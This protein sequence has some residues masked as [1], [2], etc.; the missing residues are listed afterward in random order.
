MRPGTEIRFKLTLDYSVLPE[1]Y[2]A[3]TLM[4]MI[5]EFD[6]YYQRTYLSRFTPPYDAHPVSYKNSLIL[7]GGAGFFAKTLAYPYLGVQQ[8]MP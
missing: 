5:G 6:A 8:G 1:E 3:D 2:S 7:G 4:K